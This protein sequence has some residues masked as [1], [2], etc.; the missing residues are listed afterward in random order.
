MKRNLLITLLLNVLLSTSL[1]AETTIIK[2]YILTGQS[3]GN[4]YGLAYGDVA[5]GTLKP[6]QDLEAIGRDDLITVN[7]SA[8]IYLGN[9]STG[10]G[11]WKDLGPGFASWNGVRFGPELSFGNKVQSELDEPIAIIKY[12]PNGTSLYKHWLEEKYDLLMASIND[13]KIQAASKNWTLDI[14]GLLWMQGESDSF[15]SLA[16]VAYEER[17]TTF[18]ARVRDEL[19]L[20][21]LKFHVAE[22]ADSGVW[23]SRQTIW[24]AQAA[25]TAADDN[26]RLVKSRD[27]PLFEDDAAGS[28]WVHYSTEGTVMLGEAFAT[29]V[30]STGTP[31]TPE[32]P[33]TPS[34]TD[35]FISHSVSDDS[36][37]I[38]GNLDD[39]STVES[40]GY[41]GDTL[42]DTGVK[43]DYVEGWIAHD[44][45][46]VYVAYQNN[47]DID[48]SKLWPWQLYFDTD[49]ANSTGF[50]IDSTIG[51]EFMLQGSAVYKYTGSGTNWSWQYVV[52]ANKAV[53][54]P[55]AEFQIPRL[56]LGF[57]EQLR[58]TFKARNVAFTGSY[59]QSG[60]DTYPMQF[61][62]IPLHTELLHG[63]SAIW[64]ESGGELPMTLAQAAAI[65]A[66]ELEMVETYSLFAK[67]LI[68]YLSE[69]GEY[70]TSQ[71]ASV[72]GNTINLF[73]ALE[74]PIAQ[75]QNLWNF[76]GDDSHANKLG[77]R[78][79]ADFAI[80]EAGLANLNKGKH[81]LMGDS[82]FDQPDNDLPARLAER[83]NDA[84]IV[85][86]SI[87]GFTSADVLAN[88]DSNVANQNPDFVWV[89]VGI[90]DAT[91]DV[92]VADYLSNMQIILAKIRSV[93]AQPV[94]LDSQVAQ[95][96]S[97][98]DART[99]LTHGYSQ[100]LY[101]V[102]STVQYELTEATVPPDN[103]A[104]Y[105]PKTIMVD[106]NLA[107]WDEL[108][109]FAQDANDIDE[110]GAKADLLEAWMAHDADSFYVAYKNDGD[111]D[112]VFWWPWQFFLDTDN[113]QGTGFQI[114]N[115]VGANYLIQG[116]YIFSYIGNGFNW[117]WQYQETAD[118]QVSGGI[119]EL[120]FPRAAINNP[121]SLST[122]L[123]ARNGIFTGNFSASGVDS[124][125]D[126]DEGHFNYSFID[127]T[128]ESVP[129]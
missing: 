73:K 74:A 78:A 66:T 13:A 3:N 36:I 30:M 40:L 12:T 113:K 75:G 46:N 16:P 26:A 110:V 125:P 53:S 2:T 6:N 129:Q 49:G 60:V 47:G 80:R 24:D 55:T 76:Y 15:G 94:V 86:K 111:I 10:L 97:G 28:K 84:V 48:T 115:G 116:G 82:W 79:V 118:Y 83:L 9:W 51:A 4:G 22:I 87:G 29:S 96:F 100:A 61:K 7:D 88:F 120:K 35:G 20:P 39:W 70:Y 37:T 109:S 44:N 127:P 59:A 64:G 72:D 65:G 123:K 54:G 67:Q 43:A 91:S 57:P 77:F 101:A 119:A 112:T 62:P 85:N 102:D 108:Q 107:D 106:A 8:H 34:V 18:I 93:G 128:P 105:N 58:V 103:D 25:V 42:Q 117:A 52:A 56:A 23:A 92:P 11:T 5:R 14:Q 41:E 122:V 124:F 31:Q 121:D 21:E 63:Q 71:V 69:D 81:V 27:F 50:K 95:L 38:D 89:L 1:L 68:T 17:L 45:N 114:G 99:Q 33:S 19:A 90:N 126:L 32:N 104:I 98:S